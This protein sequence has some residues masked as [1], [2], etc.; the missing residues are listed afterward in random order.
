MGQPLLLTAGVLFFLI[1]TGGR[2]TLIASGETFARLTGGIS[3]LPAHI[4]HSW[5]AYMDF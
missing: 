4:R 2:I 3:T 1:L 5:P